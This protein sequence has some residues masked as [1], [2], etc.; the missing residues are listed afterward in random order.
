MAKIVKIP[1]VMKNGEKA[2]DMKSL[3]DNFDAE[4]VVGYFLNGKLEKWLNDRYYEEEA[5]A[6]ASLEKDDPELTKK[7]CAVFG[8]EYEDSDSLDAEEIA[9]RN[10]RIARLKQL[11]DDEE[12]LENVDSVAFDQEELAEL[13]DRKV[14]K[15]Y[16]CEA[17]FRIP[18]SKQKLEYVLIGSAKASGLPEKEPAVKE[19]SS[20]AP[21]IQLPTISKIPAD[22]ADK[23]A[24]NNYVL[25]D[26]YVVWYVYPG[27]RSKDS[28]EEAFGAWNRHTGECF[29]F[30][31]PKREFSHPLFGQFRMFGSANRLVLRSYKKNNKAELLLYDMEQKTQEIICPE[32]AS[33]QLSVGYFYVSGQRIAYKD[34]NSCI[35][36]YDIDSKQKKKFPQLKHAHDYVLYGTKLLY[37]NY[38]EKAFC[39]FDIET[40]EHCALFDF[41]EEDGTF[42]IEQIIPYRERVYLLI[43]SSDEEDEEY[44]VLWSCALDDYSEHPVEHFRFPAENSDFKW[45]PRQHA[46]YIVYVEPE[47]ED[48]PVNVFNMDTQELTQATTECGY[49]VY[50]EAVLF[51]SSE[52]EYYKGDFHVVGDYLYFKRGEDEKLCRVDLSAADGK[53]CEVKKS[54]STLTRTKKRK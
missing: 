19:E 36:I 10:E 41:D 25:L 39:S 11:T 24:M 48:F 50:S 27:A 43:T 46:P 23:I 8:V 26:D 47:D 51:F 37:R 45:D 54:K 49:S 15:I 6:V 12:I 35:L 30:D 14:Q 16:L 5:E 7:L 38:N 32:Y 28:Q 52:T 22:V 2:T 4:S 1:L 29:Y 21:S 18:K 53:V 13:Y 44:N 3:L 40:E 33:S 42:R 20:T 34:K 9:W 31:I 17:D